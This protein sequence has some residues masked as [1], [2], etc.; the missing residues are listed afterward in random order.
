VGRNERRRRANFRGDLQLA[1]GQIVMDGSLRTAVFL[2]LFLDRRAEPDDVLPDDDPRNPG[3]GD[4]RGWWGDWFYAEMLTRLQAVPGTL[5]PP[6]FRIGSRLWLLARS[7]QTQDVVIRAR[8]Y[9]E[10][11]LQWLLDDKIASAVTVTTRILR[12][13]VLG[14]RVVIQRGLEIETHEFDYVW[15]QSLAA[16]S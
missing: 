6:S 10:E 12:Q 4:P 8:Q 11:A 13:G 5:T 3:R 14:L 7:K 16:V 15:A 2:S 1:G 9:A